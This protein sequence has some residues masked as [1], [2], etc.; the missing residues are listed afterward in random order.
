MNFKDYIKDR[1]ITITLLLFAVIQ[2]QIILLIYPIH[3]LLRL[4]FFIVPLAGYFLGIYFEYR[5]KKSF[6]E[7]T[8]GKLNNLDEKYLIAEMLKVPAFIEECILQTILHETDKAMIE[9]INQYKYVQEE[10]K[11]YI[12]LWIHEVKLPIATSKMIIENNPNSITLSI[13]EELS[14]IENYIEQ[15]LYYARSE[16]ANNDYYIKKCNLK[17]IVNEVIKKNKKNLITKKIKIETNN[18]E[19]II[20]T[21][22]K[23]TQFIL[24]QII[25]NS[26]KYKKETDSVIICKAEE[27]KEN[28]ILKIIDNGIGIKEAELPKVFDKGF[29][30]TNG[31]IEKKSTG[32]GLF[33]CKKLCTKLG[34]GI[35]INSIEN[36]ET[37]VKIIFPKNSFTEINIEKGINM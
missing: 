2:I 20:Y 4:Y 37:E 8:L 29:T 9:K 18:I 30:G 19:K 36:K 10:Y 5:K 27:K 28:V 16:I 13:D 6:Y 35:E 23:W 25:Q 22:Q 21:D 33:L 26:I 14:E 11:D 17:D 3:L 1:T 34:M 24:N 12:E 31:R 7:E 32:I 15:A